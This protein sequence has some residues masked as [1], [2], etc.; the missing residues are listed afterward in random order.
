MYV[1]PLNL[2]LPETNF[3]RHTKR[4]TDHIYGAIAYFIFVFLCQRLFW[5][6]SIWYLQMETS[7]RL[8]IL[9]SLEC[10]GSTLL[11]RYGG[12]NKPTSSKDSWSIELRPWGTR[13]ILWLWP[14]S[15]GN[16]LSLSHACCQ[17]K[18]SQQYQRRKPIK[19]LK[20]AK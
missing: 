9:F 10:L 3:D 20:T 7:R 6:L 16:L 1:D 11:G 17:E 2:I 13:R 8:K 14:V 5:S 18:N 4:N 19:R 12:W 15:V